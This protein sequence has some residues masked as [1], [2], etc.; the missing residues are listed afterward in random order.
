MA[1]WLEITNTFINLQT[2]QRVGDLSRAQQQ[3]ADQTA[4][5][6][7]RKER[8][9][10][11]LSQMVDVVV[12]V[13]EFVQDQQFLDAL[14][15]AG[16]GA[17]AFPRLFPQMVDADTKLKASDIQVK[18]LE[19]IRMSATDPLIKPNLEVSLAG[20]LSTFN[21]ALQEA[22][23]NLNREKRQLV[24]LD[25]NL[26][27]T[28]E[29]GEEL[30]PNQDIIQPYR[31]SEMSLQKGVMFRRGSFYRVIG[32]S[33]TGTEGFYLINDLGQNHFLFFGN[34]G[35]ADLFSFFEPPLPSLDLEISG[36]E[37]C[38]KLFSDEFLMQS[39][40]SV[41]GEMLSIF[42]NALTRAGITKQ[43]LAD[44]LHLYNKSKKD[45]LA[46]ALQAPQLQR[47]S[48]AD[49]PRMAFIIGVIIVLIIILAIISSNR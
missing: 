6:E 22:I 1:N 21:S 8:D 35:V 2:M 49:N 7:L 12:K 25:P 15:S 48:K 44:S 43:H 36:W 4:M 17:M 30:T 27:W 3:V 26:E 11:L 23:A 16:V 14:L 37:L 40:K 18:F 33:T 32:V 10:S 45:L 20:Y 13:R 38:N 31:D 28:F 34:N 42:A 47:V 39:L 29:L 9:N 41:R 5:T 19:T 46:R 24:W